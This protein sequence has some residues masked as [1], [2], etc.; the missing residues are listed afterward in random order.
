MMLGNYF[1]LLS[2]ATLAFSRPGSEIAS[3]RDDPVPY[4]A[5]PS[6]TPSPSVAPVV[7]PN[8]PE[9]D[10]SSVGKAIIYNSCRFPIYVWSVGSTITPETTVLPSKSFSET[11]RVDRLTGGIAL[12]ITTVKDGLFNSSPQTIFAYN[13]DEQN[14]KVWYD[15]T[16]V[17]GDPFKGH[18]VSL[19]P[20]DPTVFW[21]NGIPP[22]GSEVRVK[23]S[24]Q[25]LRLYLC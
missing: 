11:Y 15:L 9:S 22:A 6:S 16:D 20:S 17:F 8:A 12:K 13:L 23:P 5:F 21:P 10:A 3:N 2:L 14:S 4:G 18:P 19:L 24:T 1:S 25:D 7:I